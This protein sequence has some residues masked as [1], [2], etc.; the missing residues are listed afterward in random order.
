LVGER[1]SRIGIPRDVLMGCMHEWL[2]REMN[3]FALM[4]SL[5]SFYLLLRAVQPIAESKLLWFTGKFN[6][7]MAKDTAYLRQTH[8]LTGL[9]VVGEKIQI[10]CNKLRHLFQLHEWN[11]VSHNIKMKKKLRL[12]GK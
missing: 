7:S 10:H 3:E 8:N 9:E 1:N 5:I 4:N 12:S 6:N 11:T 2:N